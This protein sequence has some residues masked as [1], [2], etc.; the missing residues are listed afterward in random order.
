MEIAKVNKQD[1]QKAL[2]EAGAKETEIDIL[3]N[4]YSI[5]F[6]NKNLNI[7]FTTSEV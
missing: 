6:I 4:I 2:F 5:K 3:K 1:F 7:I